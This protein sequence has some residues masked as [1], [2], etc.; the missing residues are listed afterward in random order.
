MPTEDLMGMQYEKL[1]STSPA[2][3]Q[4]FSGNHLLSVDTVDVRIL[5]MCDTIEIENHVL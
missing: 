1:L 5:P 4:T 3:F 2:P